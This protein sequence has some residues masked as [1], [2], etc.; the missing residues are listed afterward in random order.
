[1]TSLTSEPTTSR[2]SSSAGAISARPAA[3]FPCAASAA[4]RKKW[5]SGPNVAT[6]CSA[7]IREARVAR[8]SAVSA[9]P[10]TSS[11]NAACVSIEARPNGSRLSS[12]P[13][14]AFRAH[15][16]ARSGS[17]RN[18]SAR[19]PCPY[20]AS[21]G[22][23]PYRSLRRSIG[24]LVTSSRNRVKTWT[25]VRNCPLQNAVRPRAS[26]TRNRNSG[27]CCP[28]AMRASSS[29][30]ARAPSN[31]EATICAY[32]TAWTI[33]NSWRA[34][35]SFTQSALVV[36]PHRPRAEPAREIER[37]AEE[38]A[39]IELALAPL[40]G[41]GHALEQIERQL[42]A[43]DRLVLRLPL[44]RPRDAHVE[45]LRGAERLAA[46]LE[47][48]RELGGNLGK[49]F[50]RR[51]FERLGDLEVEALA[52]QPGNLLVDHLMMERVGELVAQGGRAVACPAGRRA[53]EEMR[54]H[55][56]LGHGVDPLRLP[57][58]GPRDGRRGERRA[59]HAGRLEQ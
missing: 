50:P 42:G 43:R 58:D 7:A 34:W 10:H 6:A 53:Q 45:V 4:P 26:S 1:M 13:A 48:H 19:L 51:G 12:E 32:H 24:W 38:Q 22:S 21:A 30:L 54:A 14:I 49:A 44:L 29:M 25:A 16:R 28:S 15:S 20:A 5:L 40:R 55:H 18:Q 11:M 3:T 46:L 17:P 35:A 47:V 33:S 57:T 27:P 2:C 31:F 59:D 41:V 36:V 9:S 8:S 23:T 52:P 56:L 39:Q 37:H